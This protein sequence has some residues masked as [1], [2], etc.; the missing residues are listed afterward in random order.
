MAPILKDLRFEF[1]R[2][3]AIAAWITPAMREVW[4]AARADGLGHF[5]AGSHTAVLDWI[6]DQRDFLAVPA[7]FS[8]ADRL[9]T[10][11]MARHPGWCVICLGD[12]F[13]GYRGARE[14]RAPGLVE[15]EKLI[16]AA[17]AA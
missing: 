13:A 14:C 16:D 10:R 7:E 2:Q 3:F 4:T 15:L 17:E 9:L 1:A 12:G 11:C 8:G 5:S 6:H